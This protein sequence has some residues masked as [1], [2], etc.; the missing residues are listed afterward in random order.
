MK[1]LDFE[2]TIGEV[3]EKIDALRTLSQPEGI[4]IDAELTRLQAKLQKHLE[5]AYT[6]LTAW[7]KTCVARHEDRPHMIDY[8]HALIKDFVE[9]RG[10]RCFG[11]DEA[12]IGGIGRFYGRTV[13]ILGQEKGRDTQ[14]RVQHNFGMARPE[15]YRKATRL[16]QMAEHFQIP[17]LTFVD[18]AGAFPG[19]EGEERGQAE[20]IAKAMDISFD[21]TVPVI[22]T[23]IGEGGSGGAIALATANTVMML[24]HSIYS[25]I[26]PEGCAAI[27]YKDSSK[28]EQAANSLHLTAQDLMDLK[29]IDEIIPEPFGGAHRHKAEVIDAVGKAIEKHLQVYDKMDGNTIRMTRQQKFMTMTR[30]PLQ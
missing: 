13:M 8:I 30:L 18:T 17:V 10:D 23:I 2:K 22:A 1:T 26:S 6:H 27:L 16:M 24:E 28:A 21:L 5:L 20:A 3:E 29:I 12:I 4:D 11:E 25:V 7:Q 14:T 19:V 15:G 9:L